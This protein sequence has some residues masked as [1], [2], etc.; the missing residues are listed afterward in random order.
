MRPY[1]VVAA[2]VYLAAGLS[3]GGAAA[4]HS[5]N[6]AVPIRVEATQVEFRGLGVEQT[7]H[8]V[9]LHGFVR[10]SWSEHPPAVALTVWQGG[11]C[12]ERE[13]LS[14]PHVARRHPAILRPVRIET[15]PDHIEFLR[16]AEVGSESAD[17]G[18]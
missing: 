15:Q 6:L 3:I 4:A 2:A 10:E 7:R 5:T 8:G 12:L 16:I 18:S 9:E 13:A 11:R 14:W 17:C 1:P